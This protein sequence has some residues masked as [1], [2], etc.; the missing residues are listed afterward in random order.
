MAMLQTETIDM[1]SVVAEVRTPSPNDRQILE[2]DAEFVFARQGV[3]FLIKKETDDRRA[4]VIAT[5]NHEMIVGHTDD[6]D[7]IDRIIQAFRERG[8]YVTDIRMRIQC[9]NRGQETAFMYRADGAGLLNVKFE[10]QREGETFT[11]KRI[12]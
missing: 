6:V 5:A 12:S 8:A 3:E 4:I 10:E 11:I 2:S 7:V 9:V 1:G